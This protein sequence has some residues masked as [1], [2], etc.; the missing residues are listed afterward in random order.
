MLS[1]DPGVLIRNWRCDRDSIH[2][3]LL[4]RHVLGGNVNQELFTSFSAILPTSPCGI[5]ST[6]RMGNDRYPAGGELARDQ[7]Q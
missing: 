5:A 4:I 6:R 2:A 1:P 7:S 3:Q